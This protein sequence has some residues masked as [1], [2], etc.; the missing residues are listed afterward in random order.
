MKNFKILEEISKL[1]FLL[2]KIILPFW[3]KNGIDF[4][5]GGFYEFIKNSDK[6][7]GEIRR[8]RLIARQIYSFSEGFALG[9]EGPVEKIIKHGLD[10]FIKNEMIS[11][12]GR[13]A[14]SINLK[15][16]EVDFSHDL[17]DYAFFLFCLAEISNRAKFKYFAEEYARKT[18]NYLE[19]NWRHSKIGFIEDPLNTYFLKSNPHMHMLEACLHWE[20]KCNSQIHQFRN[21]ADEIVELAISKFIDKDKGFLYELFNKDWSIPDKKEFLIIEPGHQF[22]WGY[23]LLQWSLLRDNYKVYKYAKNLI[24]IG[25]QFGISNL[26][27]SVVNSINSNL[28]LEDA[29]CKLWPQTERLKV[30]SLIVRNHKNFNF[31]L[32]ESKNSL[33]KSISNLSTF[34]QKKE[35]KALWEEILDINGNFINIPNKASSLYH[36]V[37]A[38][39]NLNKVKS[40]I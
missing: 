21:I 14:K 15:N 8:T 27:S 5:K 24:N 30:W 36:I 13:L 11:S 32:Q 6:G 1:E 40:S 34:L 33:S 2:I 4:N 28:S 10:F 37:F 3:E 19:L 38:I 7:F 16:S 17:Y 39:S 35:N 9:W 23:L 20:V 25:E 26:N 31:E 12:S 18:L 22:E 29:N